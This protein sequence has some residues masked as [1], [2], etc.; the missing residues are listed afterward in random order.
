MFSLGFTGILWSVV[1]QTSHYLKEGY[2]MWSVSI[3]SMDCGVS[4]TGSSGKCRSRFN[5]RPLPAFYMSDYSVVGL[6]V[7]RMGESLKV[8]REEGFR[9]RD[10]TWGPEVVLES[11]SQLTQ[12]LSLLASR[13][14]SG[15][16]ADLVDGVYQG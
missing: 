4:G 6:K 11:P 14:I 10:E 3:V 7:D 16:I 2:A 8:M 12:I 9:I 1:L 13:G 5:E 15:Q